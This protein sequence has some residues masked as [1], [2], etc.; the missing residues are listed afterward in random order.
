MNLGIA[1]QL[2]KNVGGFVLPRS[3]LASKNLVAPINAPGLID[4]GYTGELMVPL[5]NELT[6]MGFTLQQ[7]PPDYDY[8][9]GITSSIM[10]EGDK[11]IGV[12]DPRSGDYMSIGISNKK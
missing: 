11:L 10:I 4:P 8:S 7:R 6:E 5:M 1:I 9:N 12:S 3:G 2:P